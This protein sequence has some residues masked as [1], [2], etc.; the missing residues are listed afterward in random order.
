MKIDIL[1]AVDYE[2]NNQRT[3][4]LAVEYHTAL[5]FCFVE[6]KITGLLLDRYAMTDE[7]IW[8]LVKDVCEGKDASFGVYG[9]H[10]ET[11][12]MQAIA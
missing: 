2:N 12:E 10:W 1:Y 7:E 3:S 6:D 4:L 11:I 8:S 5:D 9:F